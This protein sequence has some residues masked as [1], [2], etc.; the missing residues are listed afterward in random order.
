[1]Y[2]RK[3]CFPFTSMNTCKKDN[4]KLKMFQNFIFGPQRGKMVCLGLTKNKNLVE[5]FFI[6]CF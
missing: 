1:M 4:S 6:V 3:I 5:F 2:L